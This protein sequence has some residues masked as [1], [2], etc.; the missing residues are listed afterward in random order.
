[1]VIVVCEMKGPITIDL[2][3]KG[4]G[5]NSASYCQLLMQNSPYLLNGPRIF[6]NDFC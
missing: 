3:K 2:L 1:M 4:A 5:I 6:R